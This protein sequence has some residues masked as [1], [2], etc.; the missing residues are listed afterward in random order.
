MRFCK[1]GKGVALAPVGLTTRLGSLPGGG[2]CGVSLVF[3]MN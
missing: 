1:E 3:S 2:M